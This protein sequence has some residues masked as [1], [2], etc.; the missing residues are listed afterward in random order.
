MINHRPINRQNSPDVFEILNSIHLC[1]QMAAIK[2]DTSKNIV[3][4]NG[5]SKIATI[6][7]LDFH[8]SDAEF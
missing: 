6:D 2:Q 3:N 8:K 4:S 7:K 1:V 5:T